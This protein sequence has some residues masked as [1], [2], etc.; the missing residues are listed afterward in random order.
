MEGIQ[1]CGIPCPV[2]DRPQQIGRGV[3]LQAQLAPLAART[4][5]GGYISAPGTPSA[6]ALAS[7]RHTTL[8]PLQCAYW[9]GA[10]LPRCSPLK[11]QKLAQAA[12]RP[13]KVSGGFWEVFRFARLALRWAAAAAVAVVR[14][15]S[16]SRA[17][18]H[19]LLANS[20]TALAQKAAL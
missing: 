2:K 12:A 10:T 4:A 7:S 9:P 11:P 17:R 15:R 6:N 18:K 3:L 8:I 13:P 20:S 16:P 19:S 5:A 1:G 14:R